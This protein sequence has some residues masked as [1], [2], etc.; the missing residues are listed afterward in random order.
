MDQEL[1]CHIV[2]QGLKLGA[3]E[4]AALITHN[5]SR[6]A[7]FANSEITV[8]KVWELTTAAILFK[9]K[10]KITVSTL[11]DISPD[12]LK[13]TLA[14]LD[15]STRVIKPHANYAELPQG[16][17]KYPSIAHTYDAKLVRLGERCVDYAERAIHAALE[18]G[19]ARVAGTFGSDHTQT[20]LVT[21]RDVQTSFERTVAALEVR[22]LADKEASGMSL[23]CGSHLKDL[24]PERAGR[25][26]GELAI[27]SQNPIAGKAGRYDVV[28]GRP[29][30]AVL[31]DL[32][33]G[34]SSAYYV[35]SGYSCLAGKLGKVVASD[36]LTLWDDA[37][38]Q[39]GLGARPFDAEGWPTQPTELIRAGRLK[40]YLHNSLT[41]KRYHTQT[42]ANAGW[43]V[44][45]AWNLR[46]EGGQLSDDEL[47]AE[48]RRGL[49]VTNLGYVRFQNY[50]K[51]D[52]S[53]VIRDGVYQIRDG[54]IDRAVRGLRL[55]DNLIRLLRGIAGLSRE[56]LPTLHWWMEFDTPVETPVMLVRGVNFTTPT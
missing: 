45:H 14:Q 30:A 2:A 5:T 23:T 56:S 25:E 41:A 54:E 52:F 37:T 42:T 7:R 50:V 40:T 15:S 26:A 46:V 32:V 22:A 20:W 6:Q 51:G 27:M 28:F 47:L 55:S 12:S 36:Q 34:I 38:R 39:G 8:T 53:A 3:D 16:P 43:I 9:K 31:I 19:A 29:A 4:V 13:R 10:K 48:V 35:D 33:G 17:F 24:D 49:Y 1:A 44:P 18:A 11:T 21:S